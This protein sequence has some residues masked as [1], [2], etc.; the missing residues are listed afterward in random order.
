MKNPYCDSLEYDE[1]TFEHIILRP[2]RKYKRENGHSAVKYPCAPAKKQN[3]FNDRITHLID[4]GIVKVWTVEQWRN[5][6]VKN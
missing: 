6:R 5:R 4:T 3:V 2:D 1:C